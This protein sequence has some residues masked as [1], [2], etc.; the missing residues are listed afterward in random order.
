MALE[1]ELQSLKNNLDNILRVC[2]RLVILTLFTKNENLDGSE[3][4]ERT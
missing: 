3:S 4:N 2:L 1:G